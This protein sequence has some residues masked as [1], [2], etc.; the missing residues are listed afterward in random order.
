MYRNRC[1]IKKKCTVKNLIFDI[2]FYIHKE[3]ITSLLKNN[4]QSLIILYHTD[5]YNGLITGTQSG[6]RTNNF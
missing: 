5:K 3:I 2:D 4:N 1:S 6:T